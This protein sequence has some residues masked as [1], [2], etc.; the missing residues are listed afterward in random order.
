[1]YTTERK[2]ILNRP[3]ITRSRHYIRAVMFEHIVIL[4]I[5][6]LPLTVDGLCQLGDCSSSTKILPNCPKSEFT[7]KEVYRPIGYTKP[8]ANPNHLFNLIHDRSERNCTRVVLS[9]GVQDSA[10]FSYYLDVTCRAD[11]RPYGVYLALEAFLHRGVVACYHR[12]NISMWMA[13][14]CKIFGRE[15]IRFD[16]VR[17]EGRLTMQDLSKRGKT[18]SRLVLRTDGELR[19]DHR[20]C[21]CSKLAQFQETFYKCYGKL[22]FPERTFQSIDSM[23]TKIDVNLTLSLFTCLTLLLLRY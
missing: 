14:N 4:F 13:K 20:S 1:M 21:N 16:F 3:K 8:T 6:V 9:P 11:R 10:G 2:K 17:D 5:Q 18:L 12:S 22:A 19:D 15:R 23:Q 7:K